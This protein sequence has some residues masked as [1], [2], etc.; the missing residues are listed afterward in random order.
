MD[1]A[2]QADFLQRIDGDDSRASFFRHLQRGQHARMIRPRILAEDDDDVGAFQV[3][4]GHGGL[5][6]AQRFA[7][8]ESRRLMTHVGAVRQ[9]VRTKAAG[10][11]LKKKC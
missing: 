9:I 2:G 4:E 6:R 10:E 5:A 1:E 7:Q 3:V 11:E 8:S